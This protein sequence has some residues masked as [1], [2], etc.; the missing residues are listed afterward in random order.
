MHHEQPRIRT[1]AKD[2]PFEDYKFV[3]CSTARRVFQPRVTANMPKEV[4]TQC[5]QSDV[6]LEMIEEQ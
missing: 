5:T 1:H 3:K 2:L 6:S 4:R